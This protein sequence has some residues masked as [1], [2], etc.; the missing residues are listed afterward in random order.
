MRA[1][2]NQP[3]FCN[4]MEALPNL[5]KPIRVSYLVET[6]LG[7][8]ENTYRNHPHPREKP[9]D[10]VELVCTRRGAATVAGIAGPI[11][12]EQRRSTGIHAIERQK[13]SEK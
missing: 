8:Y 7:E 11:D 9:N 13:N 4:E 6:K 1:C 12:G 10:D 3:Q 2:E 5:P